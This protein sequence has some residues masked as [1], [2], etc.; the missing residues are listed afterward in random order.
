M[1]QMS[2]EV[3]AKKAGYSY[4]RILSE[5]DNIA[6]RYIQLKPGA[7]NPNKSL[8]DSCSSLRIAFG[9]SADH[10]RADT[11]RCSGRYPRQ[12]PVITSLGDCF[13]VPRGE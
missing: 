4:Q 2:R 6:T 1:I 11:L 5:G 13:S 12:G 10:G 7:E 8:K 9:Q 3:S